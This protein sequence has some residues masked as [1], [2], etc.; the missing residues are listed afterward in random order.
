[1]I[2]YYN[3]DCSKCKEALN[4][5]EQNNCSIEIRSYLQEPPT[6]EELE[7]LL[8]KLNCKVSNLVRTSEPLYQEKFADKDLTPEEWIAVLCDN[9]ILIQRPIVINSES[10]VIGR[11]PSL[12]VDFIKTKEL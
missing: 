3:P 1:M 10:A 9:P 4:I 6:K 2:I 11:P 12:V 7:D 8:T 5:L